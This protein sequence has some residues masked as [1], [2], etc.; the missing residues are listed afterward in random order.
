MTT[1][2]RLTL[3]RILL[4]PLFI[5]FILSSNFLPHSFLWALVIFIIA[6]V[7]DMLDGIIARKYNQITDLGKLLD[8]LADKMLIISALIC[9]VHLNLIN[10]V[11]VIIVIM[12]EF[13]I[14]A[15]RAFAQEKQVIIAAGM[16]GKIKTV[17]Q[18][19]CV[20]FILISQELIFANLIKN[21]QIYSVINFILVWL[22]VLF[23]VVSAI[24]YIYANIGLFCNTNKTKE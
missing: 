18:I 1:A 17:S 8:P 22:T 2:N 12:R 15:F 3:F 21:I 6:S 11:A 23:T 10:V 9:L 24:N 16:L 13:L 7:T 14:T 19:M 5:F 4:V 20:I